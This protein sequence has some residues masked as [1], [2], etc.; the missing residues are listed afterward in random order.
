MEALRST[1]LVRY[2]DNWSGKIRVG[3]LVLA[4]VHLTSLSDNTACAGCAYTCQHWGNT[5]FCMI[6]DDLKTSFDYDV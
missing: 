5:N 6:G 4:S 2:A 1:I 3:N